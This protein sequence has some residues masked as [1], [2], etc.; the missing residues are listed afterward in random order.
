LVAA[1]RTSAG[2]TR[3]ESSRTEDEDEPKTKPKT[4][5]KTSEDER[6]RAKT[7]VEDDEDEDSHEPKTRKP[8]TRQGQPSA[9]VKRVKDKRVNASRTAIN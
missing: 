6:R 4:K 7:S 9:R 2:K 3:I 8:N 1:S 5:P